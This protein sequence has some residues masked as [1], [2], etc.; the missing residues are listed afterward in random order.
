[1]KKAKMFGLFASLL[2]SSGL[3]VADVT[4]DLIALDEDWGGAEG[5]DAIAPLLADSVIAVGT[6][7]VA[8]KQMMLE[9]AANAEPASGPYMAGDYKVQFLSDDIAV[10]V[11]S[12]A[13][14]EAHW[15]LHVWQLVDGEWRVA[16][17]A[18]VP[19]D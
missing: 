4:D 14:P 18:S 17:T 2:M 5:P 19:R 15:S 7:G 6:D 8:D 13:P 12:T 16:A 1:M 9:A 10:M 3:A 11:H